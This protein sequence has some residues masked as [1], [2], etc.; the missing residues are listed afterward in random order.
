[1]GVVVVAAAR[2]IVRDGIQLPL[3]LGRGGNGHGSRAVQCCRKRQN[4]DSTV[5]HNVNV[6]GISWRSAIH[7]SPL[8]PQQRQS[9][10]F[11]VEPVVA[12]VGRQTPHRFHLGWR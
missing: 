7:D 4:D 8:R 10:F 3:Y 1:M 5:E 11:F 6:S 12:T 2:R 9:I